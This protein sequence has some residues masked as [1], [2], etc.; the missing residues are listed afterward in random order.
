MKWIKACSGFGLAAALLLTGCTTE[1]SEPAQKPE[2]QAKPVEHDY[3]T[4]SIVGIGDVHGHVEQ[5]AQLGGY[6]NALRGQRNREGGKVLVLDSGDIFQGTLESNLGE[7]AA[8]V[9]AY[10]ALKVKAAALG[11]HEFDFGP[12]GPNATPKGKDE[13]P[14]GALEARAKEASFTFLAANLYKQGADPATDTGPVPIE[15]VKRSMQVTVV[16]INVGII[17][18]M[19]EEALSMTHADNVR[20]LQVGPLAPALAREAAALRAKGSQVIVAL[21]HAGGDCKDL[22]HPDDVTSCNDGEVFK[23]ARA[24]PEHSVDVIVAGHTH[25]GI[26]QRVNGVAII[27]SFANGHAFGRVDVRFDRTTQKVERVDI[28]PP[29][30]LCLMGLDGKPAS[31]AKCPKG[32]KYE[33]RLVLPDPAVRKAVKADIEA[34]KSKRD[35]AL[36]VTLAKPIN[37]VLTEESPLGNLAADV[38]LRAVPRA[39]AAFNNG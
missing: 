15:G 29:Q 5:M 17:G 36:G 22:K 2:S 13:N 28:K 32:S 39:D 31:D 3:A 11:N 1:K 21:V 27:Q 4:L 26:A 24:L 10:R 20:D 34:A 23:V 38:L 8:M 33:G 9:H 35:E 12:V 7:G 18:G 25:S 37:R 16:G 30:E 6:L 14:R 19:T